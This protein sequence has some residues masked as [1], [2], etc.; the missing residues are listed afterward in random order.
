MV[1]HLPRKGKSSRTRI[2]NVV[3]IYT[4]DT[5]FGRVL[6]FRDTNGLAENRTDRAPVYFHIYI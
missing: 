5:V 4:Y 1:G 3:I 2:E 6:D